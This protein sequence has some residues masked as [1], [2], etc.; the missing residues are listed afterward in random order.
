LIKRTP[1]AWL[2]VALVCLSAFVT[3]FFVVL[4]GGKSKDA[5]YPF[6]STELVLIIDAGHGGDDS[7]AISPGG[8][9]ESVVNLAV[10]ERIDY[11]AA[12][13]G[14][15]TVMTR[16]TP[17]I[18]YSQASTTTRERKTED[19]HTRLDLI[20][21]TPNAVF[22]SIHQNEFTSSEPFG[23]Q[24]LYAGTPGSEEFGKALQ[25]LMVANLIEGN[26]RNAERISE[27]I[28]LMNNIDCPAVLV[29]CAFLSNAAEEELLRTD[30][31]RTKIATVITAGFLQNRTALE[32]VYGIDPS[33][34]LT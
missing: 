31:Y 14:V 3:V 24:A 13:F 19:Q 15:Q 17:E 27:T 28:F 6:S 4:R 25:E 22:L 1:G 2:V 16:R 12:F 26:R 34:D 5:F 23:G 29:E 10:A 33:E 7:G 18:E 30:G 11:L 20:N 8:M 32:V 21:S 9:Y